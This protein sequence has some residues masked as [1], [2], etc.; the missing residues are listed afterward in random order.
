MK[1][2]IY[3]LTLLFALSVSAQTSVRYY[4]LNVKRG[5]AANVLKLFTDFSE[6]GKW[7]SGGVMLQG[8]GF[9]NGVTH[10]IVVWGDP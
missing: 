3:S 7:K 2:I 8:V 5:Q 6:G 9:K 1:N 10:I 4:N